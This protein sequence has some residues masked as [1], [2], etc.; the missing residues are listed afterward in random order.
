M[1]NDKKQQLAKQLATAIKA[2]GGDKTWITA[3]RELME[4][5]EAR[6]MLKQGIAEELK[7][8]EKQAQEGKEKQD[9]KCECGE[10]EHCDICEHQHM[11]G[12]CEGGVEIAAWVPTK[13]RKQEAASGEKKKRRG[14]AKDRQD[15]KGDCTCDPRGHE[16]CSHEDCL[17]C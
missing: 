12:C 11:D 3:V 7:K 8:T 4:D 13:K 15:R 1:D 5:P 6:E 2:A 10:D 17:V 16:E 9:R 14:P